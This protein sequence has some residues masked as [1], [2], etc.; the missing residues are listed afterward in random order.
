MV[1]TPVNISVYK[2]FV[3]ARRNYEKRDLLYQAHWI[4][5]ARTLC[6]YISFAL[7]HF[8]PCT[9]CSGSVTTVKKSWIPESISLVMD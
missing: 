2:S 3:S 4:L 8:V 1:L 5:A 7:E 6:G 9:K